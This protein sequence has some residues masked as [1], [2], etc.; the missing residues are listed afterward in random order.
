M[1]GH[2]GV[3]PQRERLDEV[4]PHMASHDFAVTNINAD[5]SV[6]ATP[7]PWWQTYN[8]YRARPAVDTAATNLAPAFVDVCAASCEDGGLV[9]ATVVLMNDGGADSA[10]DVMVSLYAVDGATLTLIDQQVRPGVV[11]SGTST[12][13]LTFTFT[14]DQLGAD[15][16]TVIVDDDGTAT[17][18]GLQ[19]ECDES[20][21]EDSWTDP[22]CP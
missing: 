3:W 7:A 20:D 2:H 4:G 6:P 9:E 19:D 13:S 1:V 12:D 16:L 14:A 10:E 18:T 11:E 21:N 15:G 22:V 5:G 8:V 17:G